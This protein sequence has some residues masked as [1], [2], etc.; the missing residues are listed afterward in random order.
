M[1][2]IKVATDF[3][4]SSTKVII[5]TEAGIEAFVVAS[6]TIEVPKMMLQ[7][8]ALGSGSAVNPLHSVYVSCQG[9]YYAVGSLAAGRFDAFRGLKKPKIDQAAIKVLGAVWVYMANHQLDQMEIDLVCCLPPGEVKQSSNFETAL[10]KALTKFDTPSG[11]KAVTLDKYRCFPEGMGIFTKHAQERPEIVS[12][13]QVATF[14]LGFRNASLFSAT[15]GRLDYF[16]STDLGFTKIVKDIID[17]MGDYHEDSLIEAVSKYRIGGDEKFLEAILRGNTPNDRRQELSTLKKTIEAV[18]ERYLALLTGW[19]DENLATDVREILVCGGT[20]DTLN[21]E[22]LNW[23]RTKVPLRS[24]K[25]D[26]YGVFLHGGFNP[27]PEIAALGYGN[28][29]ADIYYLSQFY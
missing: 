5:E 16:R 24:D 22:L 25:P 1:P 6:E 3:G 23:L 14:I 8:Y 19:L 2:N 17:L 18:I 26:R 28:R 20:V 27:P 11:I 29:F 21:P 12:Q 10:R 7:G 9:K 4:G 13:H 15:G